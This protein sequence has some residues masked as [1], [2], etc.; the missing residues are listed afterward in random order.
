MWFNILAGFGIGLLGSFHCVGMCGPIALMLPVKTTDPFLKSFRSILYNLG[1]ACSY[2][3]LGLLSGFIGQK[4]ALLGFQQALSIIVGSLIL[5]WVWSSKFK[6]FSNFRIPFLSIPIAKFKNRL[7]YLLHQQK[8][9]FSFF[10]IGLL[11]G[12]LPCGL[13]YMALAAALATGSVWGAALLMF[14]FGLGTMPLMLI[15]MLSGTAVSSLFRNKV[16]TLMPYM[17]SFTALILVMRGLN[18]EIP[19]LNA[20]V[21]NTSSNT[22]NCMK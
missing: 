20:G 15:L 8:S 7:A 10:S 13:V 19:F 9:S 17:L 3:A 2:A 14:L 11:N 16:R 18:I 5:L 21:Q 4:M 22:I 6:S 1:R 12:L